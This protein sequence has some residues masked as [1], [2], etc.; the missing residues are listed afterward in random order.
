MMWSNYGSWGAG[1]WLLMS[2]MMVIFLG[3][4]IALVVWVARSI[5]SAPDRTDAN[6]SGARADEVLAER[7]ARGE[8][9]EQDFIRQRDL[10]RSPPR[11]RI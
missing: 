4:I 2:G 11:T 8:I 1:A 6:L 5:G 3:L 7:F 10:L 9:A